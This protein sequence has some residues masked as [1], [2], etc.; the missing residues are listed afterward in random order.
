MNAAR[1]GPAP[2]RARAQRNELVADFHLEESERYRRSA[3]HGRPQTGESPIGNERLDP[4]GERSRLA[5]ECAVHAFRRHE[6]GAEELKLARGPFDVFAEKPIKSR[7]FAA[8][9]EAWAS[10][11]PLWR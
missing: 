9:Y 11:H 2:I 5:G 10:A 7:E 4:C 6:H 3:R 1:L 8:A